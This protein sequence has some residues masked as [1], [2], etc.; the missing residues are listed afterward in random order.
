MKTGLRFRA[1]AEDLALELERGKYFYL[2]TFSI[3]FIGLTSLRA[4]A[5][6]LWY[7]ELFTYY[8]SRLPGMSLMWSALKDGADLNPPLL[9]LATSGAHR[10]FGDGLV[11]TRLP[12]ILGFLTML[13]CLFVFVSRRCGAGYGFAAMLFAALSGAYTFSYEARSYGMVLGFC[14]ISLV[15]WQLAADH[16]R[17]HWALG[18]LALSVGAALFTHC[19]AVLIL[20][21]LAAGE[22]T[23]SFTRK[24][25]DWQVWIALI[26][27]GCTA[28]LYL[29]LLAASHQLAL[30][31]VT[32]R[33]TL[34]VLIECY[35]M[36]IGPLAGPILLALVIVVVSR[37]GGGE[38]QAG[39]PISQGFEVYEIVAGLALA[40]IPVV[41]LLI[42]IFVS[43]V[44]MP[45][46]GLAAVIG[47]S[48]LFTWF[49]HQY[50]ADRRITGAVVSYLFA[51]WFIGAFAL[52]MMGTAH[53]KVTAASSH[54][55]RPAAYEL[56]PELVKPDLPFVAA[57]GLFFLEADHYAPQSFASRLVY[58]ADTAAAVRYTGSDVFDRGFPIMQK[59]FPIR[60]R[61]ESY[62]TFTRRHRRFLVF[63][64]FDHPLA[65]VTRKLLDDGVELRFLGQY[66][67]AYG[68]NLLLEAIMP[69]A[70]TAAAPQP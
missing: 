57:N 47:F 36:M 13:A 6:P 55:G 58:L 50:T 38:S 56:P 15:T 40:L 65:W 70:D 4:L 10:V 60:A 39:R 11:A 37:S 67:G 28:A 9:Y 54:A 32:F 61:I 30:D 45:R 22:I 68:E 23:R 1:L 66:P 7:D 26:L 24:R 3:V 62:A 2:A 31:N 8:M 52:W 41:A 35:G 43:H 18:G 16:R 17:R 21:P 48:I 49:A 33:P 12:A 44:F 59:W 20:L 27:G 46:Y 69:D 5:K 51:F 25:L 14:G 19:Y 53:L 64:S 29:P 63:G 34:R 42:A